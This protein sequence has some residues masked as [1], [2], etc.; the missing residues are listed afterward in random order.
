MFLA[1]DVVS[2]VAVSTAVRLEESAATDILHARRVLEHAVALEAAAV[3]TAADYEEL[4]R[5][6]LLLERHLGD[7]PSVMRIDAMFHRSLVRACHNATIES[8]MRGVGRGLAPIR[9]A[10]PG[11]QERDTETLQVHRDQLEAMRGGDSAALEA[12]LDRHFRMLESSFAEGIGRDVEE[13]F[14]RA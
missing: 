14:P 5:A 8:A 7:R 9:D 11:G 3:A 2:P 6:V 4:D 1:S 10:Y 13:L 12:V